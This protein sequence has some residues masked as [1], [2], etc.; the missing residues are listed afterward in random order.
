M[1]ESDFIQQNVPPLPPRYRFRDL[2]RGE[3]SPAGTLHTGGGDA[4]HHHGPQDHDRYDSVVFHAHRIKIN[5]HSTSIIP[6]LI[7]RNSQSNYRVFVATSFFICNPVLNST[8]AIKQILISSSGGSRI[9]RW[10][11]RAPT[12][13]AGA[14]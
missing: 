5:C 7:F 13:D 6:K 3:H 11:G 1:A 4:Q 10:G 2:I 8:Q 9:S 14:F 12:S